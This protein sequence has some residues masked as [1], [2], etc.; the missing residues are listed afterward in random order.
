[1]LRTIFIL[2]ATTPFVITAAG[3][4]LTDR[5]DAEGSFPQ[6]G[7]INVPARS[8]QTVY[9][10]TPYVRTPNLQLNDYKE[11][12]SIVEQGADHFRIKNISAA[13]TNVRWTAKGAVAASESTQPAT[14]KSTHP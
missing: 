1:M 10:P 11:C 5:Q 13:S 8:E 14:A 7:T 2:I 6:E 9:Y 4:L 3:C 12:V